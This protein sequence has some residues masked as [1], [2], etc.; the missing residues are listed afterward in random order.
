MVLAD[1]HYS[2]YVLLK[3][4]IIKKIFKHLSETSH[5][6]E[7]Q[8]FIVQYMNALVVSTFQSINNSSNSKS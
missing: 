2:F 6:T 4:K 3:K 5:L 8:I 1:P 7:L